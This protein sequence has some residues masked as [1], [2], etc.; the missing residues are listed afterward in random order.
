MIDSGEVGGHGGSQRRTI[1]KRKL[2]LL[3][4]LNGVQCRQ[5]EEIQKILNTETNNNN[6]IT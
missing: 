3:L 5:E 6:N 4:A 1:E 2:V